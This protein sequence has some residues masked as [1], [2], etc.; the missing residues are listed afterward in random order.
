MSAVVAR[1]GRLFDF[2][3]DK[4]DGFVV[5]DVLDDL[6]FTRAQFY[7]AVRA[8]RLILADDSINLICDQQ[9]FGAPHTYRLVG[10]FEKAGPWVRQ[11]MRGIESQLESVLAATSSIVNASDGRTL[12]GK[13]AR[14]VNRHVGRLIEDLGDLDG[15]L[16]WRE[17]ASS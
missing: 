2:A 11:R 8:L 16:P 1:A 17:V 7:K 5:Q 9:G 14:L 12:D 4:P 3:A 15:Q 6:E 13:K 10:T